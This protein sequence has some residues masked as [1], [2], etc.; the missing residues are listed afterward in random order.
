MEVDTAE[1]TPKKK[2]AKGTPSAT[3][4]KA[5]DAEPPPV[6]EV[7]PGAAP[8]AVGQRTSLDK[9]LEAHLLGAEPLATVAQQSQTAAS[10]IAPQGLDM[11]GFLARLRK[12]IPWAG[13]RQTVVTTPI[14]RR[15]KQTWIPVPVAEAQTTRPPTVRELLTKQAVKEISG[16]PMWETPPLTAL[17][18]PM[19]REGS[20]METEGQD[21]I[22][23]DKKAQKEPTVPS[24]RTV[25]SEPV[26]PANLECQVGPQR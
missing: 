18:S 1:S 9:Q 15:P 3:F 25:A 14:P 23:M 6:P 21:P 7:P 2:K 11:R 10:S 12:S 19:A 8:M 26:T 16:G 13:T 24:S 4:G 22:T 20:S 5:P 17:R